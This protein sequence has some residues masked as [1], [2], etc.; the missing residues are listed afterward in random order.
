VTSP[1]SAAKHSPPPQLVLPPPD[2]DVRA[3]LGTKYEDVKTRPR[4][5][6]T[7]DELA[8][9]ARLYGRRR[10]A[11]PRHATGKTRAARGAAADRQG[12][13]TVTGFIAYAQGWGGLYIRPTSSRTSCCAGHPALGIA[14]AAA[15]PTFPSACIGAAS[16][17][18]SSA[19]PM[20]TL[21][22]RALFLRLFAPRHQL[23]GRRRP[24]SLGYGSRSAGTIRSATRCSSAAWS[25]GS[26]PRSSDASSSSAPRR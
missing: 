25:S 17:P 7:R 9:I 12:S 24:S 10:S 20:R 15:F 8:E 16:W 18:S 11:A 21:P 14:N 23:D 22:P 2:R 3:Q 4:H 1:T 26:G 6:Y 5:V 19:R 13:M